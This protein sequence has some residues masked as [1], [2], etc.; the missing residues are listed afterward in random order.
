MLIIVDAARQS[1]MIATRQ[2]LWRRAATCS[3][4]MLSPMGRGFQGRRR[5]LSSVGLTT[6]KL[7]GS[8]SVQ[9]LIPIRVVP[10]ALHFRLLSLPTSSVT[11]ATI[12]TDEAAI[13]T[14]TTLR[15]LEQGVG[16][17]T[18]HEWHEA[19]QALSY[20]VR[21]RTSQGVDNAWKLLDRIVQEEGAVKAIQK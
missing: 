14:R 4:F 1:T 7:R 8:S 17:M 21:L 19:E 9:A 12:S 13:W 18:P 10:S 2:R 3:D 6:D 20:W 11:D 16:T 15:I 5:L